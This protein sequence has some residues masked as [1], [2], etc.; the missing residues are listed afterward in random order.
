MKRILLL[1]LVCVSFAAIPPSER[2]GCNQPITR[3]TTCPREALPDSPFCALHQPGMSGKKDVHSFAPCIYPPWCGSPAVG[4]TSYCAT[5][6]PPPPPCTCSVPM[7][8][9]D[10]CG[11]QC[12]SNSSLCSFHAAPPIPPL[13][14]VADKVYCMN[15]VPTCFSPATGGT[16]F[17]D[18]HQGTNPPPQNKP[19]CGYPVHCPPG[20][21]GPTG[22]M[23]CPCYNRPV[24]A[25]GRCATH[26]APPPPIPPLNEVETK[27]DDFAKCSKITTSGVCFNDALPGTYL[28]QTH[29]PPS[30]PPTLPTPSGFCSFPRDPYWP[31]GKPAYPQYGGFCEAHKIPP[32][33]TEN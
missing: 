14:D 25:S 10:R 27:D 6:T 2:G 20:P 32:L 22:E 9:R 13:A 21:G 29:T 11:L 8:S 3:N 30:A 1:L 26:Y 12:V 31:C 18:N 33:L 15:A 7:I 28:C 19:W 23:S 5:H 16:P 24:N 17:C 4:T